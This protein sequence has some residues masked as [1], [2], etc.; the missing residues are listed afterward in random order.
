MGT[1][2]CRYCPL[3][4]ISP[5]KHIATMTVVSGTPTLCG[6]L[7]PLTTVSGCNGPTGT[8]DPIEMHTRKCLVDSAKNKVLLAF[9]EYIKLEAGWDLV[10][11]LKEKILSAN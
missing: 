3:K 10:E 8:S 4:V 7:P 5:I 6:A 2:G 9:D 1:C 11:E